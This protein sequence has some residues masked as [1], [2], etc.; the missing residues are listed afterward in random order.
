MSEVVME[1]NNSSLAQAEVRTGHPKLHSVPPA[2]VACE[3]VETDYAAR[4]ATSPSMNSITAAPSGRNQVSGNHLQAILKHNLVES[5]ADYADIFNE[6]QI[7]PE[8]HDE[9][10]TGIIHQI[11][12]KRMKK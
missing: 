9:I 6:L 11:R 8:H 5:G 3:L 12:P 10:V 1:I 2:Q 4:N 7:K